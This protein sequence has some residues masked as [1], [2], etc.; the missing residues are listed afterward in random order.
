LEF[1]HH[2]HRTL[3][4]STHP[5]LRRELLKT[6]TWSDRLIC[7]KGFRGVGKTTFLL[8]YLKKEFPDDNSVLYVNLNNFYFTR[9][10][11]LSFADEF[12]KRGGK[13]L[14]LD[15]I[16]KYPNWSKELRQCYDRLPDLKII[17]TS[18]PVLRITEDNPHLKGIVKVNHLEGLSFREY[19]NYFTKNNFPV[20][21]IHEI[22]NNHIEIAQEIVSKVRPLA[23]FGEYLKNGIYPYFIDN[24]N[25]YSNRLLKHINLALEIDVPYINQIELKYLSKLRKLL[26]IIASETPF[27]PNVS[28]LAADVKTS[29][30]TVMNYLRYLKNAKLIQLLYANGGENELKKPDKVYMHN[31]NLLYAIAPENVEKTNLRQTFFYNQVGYILPVNSSEKADFL[32]NHSLHFVVGGHKTEPGKG[33]FAAADMIETGSNNKIPLWLF[34]FLY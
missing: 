25:F 30:A 4:E 28:K 29:R 10:T 32:V 26:Y 8:D 20:Y 5:T 18:S 27:S 34:G 9:R 11:I 15:Q 23:Y 33:Q 1:F 21:S 7:I 2:T 19:L 31:T 14:L 24:P 6:I 12:A 3:L 13:V 16:Q 22:L 17:F